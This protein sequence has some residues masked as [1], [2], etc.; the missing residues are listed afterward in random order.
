VPRAAHRIGFWMAVAL[1]MG[2]MIGSGIFLLPSSLATYG[3]V[4]LFGW[5][6]SAVGSILL[7][8]VFARMS[9]LRP[10]AGGP[11]AFTRFAFGDL[12]GFLVAWGYWLSICTGNAGI[13]LA[14]V[15]YLEP[16]VPQLVR[17]PIIASAM[18]VAAVWLLTL[19]NIWGIREAAQ[20]QL[21][22]TILK[23][24]PLVFIAGAAFVAFNPDA[25]VVTTS[26]A[27]AIGGQL[28]TAAALTFWAFGGLESATIPAGSVDNPQR[29]IPRATI[30]G[31]V[32]TAVIYIAATAGVMSVVPVDVLKTS[33]APFADAARAIAGHWAAAAVAIGAVIACF[34]CLNGWI[35]IAGQMPLAIARDGLFPRP[36]AKVS[37]RDTPVLALIVS[38]LLTTTLLALN[39]SRGLVDLFTFMILLGTLSTLVPYAFSSMAAFV[40]DRKGSTGAGLTAALA[41]GYSLWMIGGA[42]AEVVYWGFLLL[43]LG[44]P[45]YVWVG[46]QRPS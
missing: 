11:Y 9:R 25:F 38:S 40:I 6:V 5:M 16:F 46:R 43:L 31:T 20:L 42:G 19:V 17:E 21:V 41:F 45:V 36:F 13:A 8:F 18:A 3:A 32:I 37:G 4:G 30:I 14:F 29:T 15:G 12:A 2:N 26:G 22:T 28:S 44:L 34:G 39:A 33:T 35:L 7:A 27:R 24:V 10:A 23:I 1:V